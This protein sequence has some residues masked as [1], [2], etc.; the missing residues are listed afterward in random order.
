MPHI[1]I[2]DDRSTNRR[3]LERMAASISSDVSVIS[4]S[5]PILALN[6]LDENVVDLII[7]DYKMPHLNGAEFTRRARG[8]PA[9][10]DIPIIVITIHADREFRLSSLDA[11]ATD[12]L[13]SPIDPIEFSTRVRN[14]LGLRRHQVAT[15]QQVERLRVDLEESEKLRVDLTRGNREAL[16]QVIDTLHAMVSAA[17]RDG[18]LVFVNVA[19][20]SEIGKTPADLVGLSVVELFGPERGK[21]SRQFDADVFRTKK[22][23]RGLEETVKAADGTLRYLSTTKAPLRDSAGNVSA[24]LTTSID[25]TDQKAVEER[26]LYLAQHDPLTE[27]PNRAFLSERLRERCGHGRRSEDGFALHFLDLDRF[28]AVNDA[29]GHQVGDKL[30]KEVAKRLKATLREGDVV[31]RLGG[32]EFAILQHDIKSPAAASLLATRV[33]DAFRKPFRVGK[34]SIAAGTSLGITLFPKDT[35]DADALL[36]NADLAMYRAKTN[37]R[38]GFSFFDQEMDVAA[39]QALRL[40]GELRRALARGEFELA[41]QPQVSLRTGR[42]CGAEALLRWNH[43]ERGVILPTDFLGLAEEVGLIAPITEWVLATAC[44]QGAIWA[45]QRAEGVRIA[46]NLSPSLFVTRDVQRMITEA[47]TLSGLSPTLLDVEITERILLSKLDEAA[48]TLIALRE[49]GVAFSIDD[50]GTG[51]SS[52]TFV[53]SF[54]IQRLKVDQTYIG[55]L[56]IDRTDT[57]IVAGILHLAHGLNMQVVAE[58]VENASQLARLQE[59]GCDEVQGF[60]VQKPISAETLT[61]MLQSNLS[62]LLCRE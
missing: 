23:L 19:Q 21:L 60:F 29:L 43:P 24:V 45:G 1:L 10:S 26:L 36:R 58:G 14:L 27:L 15:K 9:T 59:M 47:I 7:T 16:A 28:K 62:D 41:W 44:A 2:L 6:W 32:D 46:V 50:F 35:I 39:Q 25:V 49:L 51:Y 5:D 52:L 20:A 42:I 3:V 37:S 11:G 34:L 4:F 56:G 30:L 31:A 12:F 38:G 53:R 48:A 18:Q 8:K 40:E 22:T 57:A 55:R 61:G 54:P 13:L 17:D 33:L